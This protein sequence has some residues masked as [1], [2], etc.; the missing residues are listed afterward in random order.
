MNH[1][2]PSPAK[3]LAR[4]VVEDGVRLDWMGTPS[5]STADLVLSRTLVCSMDPIQEIPRAL[6]ET[7]PRGNGLPNWTAVRRRMAD[8]KRPPYIDSGEGTQRAL[9]SQIPRLSFPPC[10]FPPRR[11]PPPLPSDSARLG[12]PHSDI[13]TISPR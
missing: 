5:C 3:F 1:R 8:Y 12:D 11:P 9:D 2:A 7:R 6:G 4:S 10:S 13:Q